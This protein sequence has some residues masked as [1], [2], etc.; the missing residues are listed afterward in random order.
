MVPPNTTTL[1]KESFE[2]IIEMDNVVLLFGRQKRHLREAIF[3]K[4]PEFYEKLSQRGGGLLVF[5]LLFRNLK[6]QN[7]MFWAR[8]ECLDVSD[9]SVIG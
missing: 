9:N 7:G 6:A 5:I 8:I 4:N 3:L 2:N 1:K